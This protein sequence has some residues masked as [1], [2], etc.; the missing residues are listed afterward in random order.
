[1]DDPKVLAASLKSLRDLAEERW[2]GHYR[3]HKREH[4]T[5]VAT[6]AAMDSRLGL[7]NEFRAQQ[8][9]N[10]KQFVTREL[11]DNLEADV[12]RRV[13]A[14][15]EE[16]ERR[17]ENDRQAI[18]LLQAENQ[19]MQGALAIARFVGFGGMLT[20]ASA[21]VYLILHGVAL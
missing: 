21:V 10:A 14:V 13:N 5:L 2:A 18:G 20:G 12:E 6:S 9:D 8:A 16:F 4:E 1:M 3:E 19:R 7:L 15:R 11:H 17:L